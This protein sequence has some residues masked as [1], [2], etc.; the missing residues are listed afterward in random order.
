MNKKA[1]KVCIEAF[2]SYLFIFFRSSRIKSAKEKKSV[3][4]M[5]Y[6]I[7]IEKKIYIYYY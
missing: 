4:R 6:K 3:E 1:M 2:P 5:R 7:Y